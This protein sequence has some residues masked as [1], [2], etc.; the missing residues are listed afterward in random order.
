MQQLIHAWFARNGE[1]HLPGVGHLTRMTNQPTIDITNKVI[2]PSSFKIVF[3]TDSIPAEKKFYYWL[4]KCLDIDETSAIRRF[5]DYISDGIRLI[6]QNTEWVLPGLGVFKKGSDGLLVFYEQAF[7]QAQF[8]ALTAE[9]VIRQDEKYVV[10]QGENE[11]NSD[12]VLAEGIANEE[13]DNWWVHAIILLVLGV[14]C[15][16]FY[17]L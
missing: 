10:L 5:N 17:H 8:Q 6:E 4:S 13:K 7:Y 14:A 2:Q 12:F 1:V 11:T 9:R 3:S 15:I 16:L